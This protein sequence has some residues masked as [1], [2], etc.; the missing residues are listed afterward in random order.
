MTSLTFQDARIALL[1]D[2]ILSLRALRY[3]L[4]VTH[5]SQFQQ[6]AEP[7]GDV[8]EHLP[9]DNFLFIPTDFSSEPSVAAAIKE[10]VRTWMGVDGLVNNPGVGPM[11]SFTAQP[12]EH[13]SLEDFNRVV[14]STLSAQWLVAKHAVAELSRTGGSIVAIASTRASQSEA[15]CSASHAAAKGGV[16]SLTH[17]LAS[18]FSD[19][20]VRVN[21]I[22]SGWIDVRDAMMTEVGVFPG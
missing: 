2:D 5:R 13:T 10:V 20:H 19:R 8:F 12:I 15:H 21:C 7:D 18:S 1:D 3:H 22:S 17:A 4:S 6:R 14:Q 9:G 16:I 11:A